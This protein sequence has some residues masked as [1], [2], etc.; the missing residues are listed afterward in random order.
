MPSTWR[1]WDLFGLTYRKDCAPE[2]EAR[3]AIARCGDLSESPRC[4]CGPTI[5][6]C[7]PDGLNVRL[8]H[9]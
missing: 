5:R 1:T 2:S 9:V 3:I 7:T 4:H 8:F 6:R